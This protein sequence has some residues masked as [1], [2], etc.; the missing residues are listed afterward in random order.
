MAQKRLELE[1]EVR[2][3][4][5]LVDQGKNFLLSG[6]AGS[7]KT[8]SLVQFIR[9]ALIENPNS[10]IACITYTNAAV[11]E[12]Q[13]R[14]KDPRLHIGTIHEF[15]WD[16]IRS[17][18]SEL[19]D[20]L[21]SSLKSEEPKTIKNPDETF[22]PE[23]LRN[24]EVQY[25]EYVLVKEAIISHDEIL[26]LASEMFKK[27]SKLSDI[28]KDRF[29]FILIDEYQDTSALVTDIFLIH[30]QKSKKNNII[31][32]F[33]DSMQSIYDGVG[34]LNK[35]LKLELVVEKEK[36]QNRR[37][38]KLIYELANRLRTDGLIQCSSTDKDAPNMLNGSVIEGDIK[39]IYTNTDLDKLDKVKEILDWDFINTKENK[40]LNLTHNL[41]APKAGFPELMLIYDGDKI[42]EYRNRIKKFIKDNSIKIDFSDFT[43]SKVIDYLIKNY[44]TKRKNIDPTKGMMPFID[45]QQEL[46]Q[47]ALSTPYKIFSRIYVKKDALIDDKKDD[48]SATNKSGS[49]RDAL[50]KHLFKI[51]NIINLYENKRYNEFLKKTEFKIRS[52][53]DK[54]RLKEIIENIRNMPNET[55]GQV[56]D[57]ADEFGLCKKDDKL[58][59]F[60]TKNK[61]VYERVIKV[62]YSEFQHL[63]NYLEGYTSYS[64]QHKIK[65][66]QFDNVL[67][68]LDN[69][70]WTLYNFTCLFEQK[71]TETVLENTR[72]LFYV[73]CTR[74]KRR[75]VVYF[76][77]PSIAVLATA[78]E[79]FGEDNVKC[80]D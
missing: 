2:E 40:V 17:Y 66:A 44:P 7:G 75:L 45:S 42:I 14:I 37:N 67:V 27:Y 79:W 72:K 53:N 24:K 47:Q 30:F 62:K 49:K 13:E 26:I 74:S 57:R 76:S 6:G 46:Y 29:K 39:F 1:P 35:Y 34:N 56:I 33:G 73:C 71:G 11:A 4:F 78:R 64:T 60:I 28:A 80:I 8:F 65:G 23:Y 25:K 20:S 36:I 48:P 5:K 55:I 63:Y 58:S 10:T 32:F 52:I 68:I 54:R 9:Q 41:I 12:I 43:F 61:Y 21:I 69:G 38:P 19:I 51:Q 22:D 31:G 77:K 15:L 16:L 18:K 70:K 50:I 3:I 59:M